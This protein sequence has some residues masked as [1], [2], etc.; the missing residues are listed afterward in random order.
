MDQEGPPTVGLYRFS[1]ELINDKRSSPSPSISPA[2]SGNHTT[3]W[4]PPSPSL[5]SSSWQLTSEAKIRK[6][7][8]D[9]LAEDSCG[10]Q[11]HHKIFM[12]GK[13]HENENLPLLEAGVIGSGRD[14]N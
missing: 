2:C 8:S 3:S 10:S 5:G 6:P 13:A 9:D 14:N 11:L 12:I 4:R 1:P 7:K